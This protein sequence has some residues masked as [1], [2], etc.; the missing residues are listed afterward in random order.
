VQNQGQAEAGATTGRDVTKYYYFNGQRVAMRGPDEAVTWIHGDHLGSTSLT[1]NE[2]GEAVARQLYE[3]FGEV[4]WVTGTLGTDIGFTG[5]RE[6]G[7][8]GLVEMGVRWYDPYLNRWIQ[9]DT[10]VPDFANPQNLNRLSY[11]KNNPLRYTDPTGHGIWDEIKKG[12]KRIGSWVLGKASEVYNLSRDAA[13]NLILDNRIDQSLSQVPFTNPAEAALLSLMG[14][15]KAILGGDAI[16]LIR[17]DPAMIELEQSIIA[18]IELDER[19]RNEPFS[20]VVDPETVAFGG[21]RA[22]A[23]MREQALAPWKPEYRDTWRVAANELTWLVRAAGVGATVYVQE[24]G[25]FIIDYHLTD[26]LDLRPNRPEGNPYNNITAILG[27]VYHDILE[28][29]SNVVDENLLGGVS[30]WGVSE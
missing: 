30:R 9:P 14:E 25:S 3:P 12:T 20:Y 10:I 8:I 28:L 13:R 4:R 11:V 7:Y 22:P 18:D 24:D 27:L 16:D 6:D 26:R 2:S 5:Q 17:A 19:Y 21:S 23:D 15:D 29:L 1:T